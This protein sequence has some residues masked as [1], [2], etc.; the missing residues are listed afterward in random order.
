[1]VKEL[2]HRQNHSHDHNNVLTDHG[3]SRCKTSIHGA[4][5]L[6]D[7]E[8]GGHHIRLSGLRLQGLNN[9]QAKDLLYTA[10]AYIRDDKQAQLQYV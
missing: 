6:N 8:K 1:M 3:G 4:P 5:H 2:L 10:L 9:Y 7:A